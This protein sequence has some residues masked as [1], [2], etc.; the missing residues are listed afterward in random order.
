MSQAITT[1][2]DVESLSKEVTCMKMLVACMLKSMG[3]VD[4]GKAILRMERQLAC[5]E[6]GEDKTQFSATLQQI[7]TAYLA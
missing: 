2:Q 3:Q 7:K 5:L 4:A 1:A 6:E